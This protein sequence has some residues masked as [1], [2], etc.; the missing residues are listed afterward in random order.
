MSHRNDIDI[1]LNKMPTRAIKWGVLAIILF[2]VGGT[3][4]G[5]VYSSVPGGSYQ[6]AQQW[7]FLGGDIKAKMTPGL[8]FPFGTT[9]DWPKGDTFFFTEQGDSDAPG[10]SSLTDSSIEVRF[11]D[12]SVGHIAGTC[13]YEFPTSPKQAID[14]VVNRGHTTALDA[15]SLLIKP[16]VRTALRL[17]ASLMTAT[18]S[19]VARA[20]FYDH[21]WRQLQHGSYLTEQHDEW[22]EDPVTKEKKL[23]SVTKVVYG[24]DG[25]PKHKQNQLAIAGIEVRNIEIKRFKYSPEVTEQIKKQQKAKMDVDIARAQALKADQDKRTAEAEGRALVARARAEEEEKKTREVVQAEKRK[26][27]AELKAAQ[28]L[29]VAKLQ[30]LASAESKQSMILVA[31]G[32]A[33]AR[34]LKMKADNYKAMKI[35]AMRDIHLSW[36]KAFSNRR[37]PTNIF[38]GSAVASGDTDAHF[39]SFKSA[40]DLL[41]ARQLGM[42]LD[43][44]ATPMAASVKPR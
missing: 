2:I 10:D 37:V 36:A 4:I 31:E 21:V 43:L 17:T 3:V 40:I 6:I 14:L 33:K 42:N 23:M 20:T 35:K 26:A 15:Q 13:R 44:G 22:V 32:E 27:V 41:V 1:D 28:E 11:K 24:K 8:W 38:G 9:W 30:K 39:M 12:G 19:Y 34:E 25:K 29:E 16:E 18:E 7:S 5:G